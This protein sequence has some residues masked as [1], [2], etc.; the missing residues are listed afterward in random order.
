MRCR[1]SQK[2]NK[3]ICLFAVKS[4]KANKKNLFLCFLG[5]SMVHQSAFGFIRPL[6]WYPD[7]MVSTSLFSFVFW[8]KLFWNFAKSFCTLFTNSLEKALQ[9]CCLGACIPIWKWTKL[10]ESY[11][12]LVIGATKKVHKAYYAIRWNRFYFRNISGYFRIAITE[13]KQGD[14]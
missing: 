12:I 5:E 13:L 2:L 8:E 7:L 4:K 10:S 6:L 11:G 1:F 14:H 3:W 9:N